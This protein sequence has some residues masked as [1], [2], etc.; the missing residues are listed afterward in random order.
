MR[1]KPFDIIVYFNFFVFKALFGHE[2]MYIMDK[3]ER[4]K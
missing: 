4:N 2:K 1:I 3:N